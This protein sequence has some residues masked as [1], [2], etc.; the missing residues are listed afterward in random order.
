M[1]IKTFLVLNSIMFIP[2]GIGMLLFPS[3]IFGMLDVQLDSDGLLMASTVGSMLL[4][5]GLICLIA[6]NVKEN[7]PALE[8]IL[9][10]NLCFHTI[11]SFLTFRGASSEVM[12]SLGYMFSS[13]HLLFAVGFLFYFI[14]L[15]NQSLVLTRD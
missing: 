5:F 14:T 13:I 1:S 15:K 8:A 3:P 10:G 2:F 4:S 7:S 11:D 12:N 9:V 6:R